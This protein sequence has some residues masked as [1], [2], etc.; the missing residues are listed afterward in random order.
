MLTTVTEVGD[1]SGPSSKG[2]PLIYPFGH[3]NHWTSVCNHDGWSV[4]S[5][6]IN[7]DTPQDNVSF[8]PLVVKFSESGKQRTEFGNR[9][10]LD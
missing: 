7:G 8:S 3:S 10:T 9:K 6:Y 2:F 4:L 5:L 1:N